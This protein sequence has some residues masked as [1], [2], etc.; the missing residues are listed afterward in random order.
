MRVTSYR[1]RPPAMPA[2]IAAPPDVISA[3]R[4]DFSVGAGP[5]PGRPDTARHAM[6]RATDA[7]LRHIIL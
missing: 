2:E 3:G 1:T 4:L 7:G 5:R 6:R